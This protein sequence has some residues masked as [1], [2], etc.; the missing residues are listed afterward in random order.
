MSG[1]LF[2]KTDFS[3]T[4][5]CPDDS[6]VLHEIHDLSFFHGWDE[7]TF[8]SFLSDPQV[9]GFTVRPVGRPKKVLGF[10]L[11]RLVVDEAEIMTIAV[12]PSYRGRGIGQKLLDAVF[13]YLYAQRTKTLFLEVDASNNAALKLYKGF[14]FQEVGKRPAYYHTDKG[15]SDALIMRRTFQQ[16]D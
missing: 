12:R 5:I 8:V 15:H 13:R 10:V 14:G 2:G 11:C 1:F 4:P 9:F 7:T 6:G 3:V 16:K